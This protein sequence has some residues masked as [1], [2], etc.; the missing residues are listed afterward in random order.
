MTVQHYSRNP[1]TLFNFEVY[2]LA[3]RACVN[4]CAFFGNGGN[5]DNNME[6]LKG[7]VSHIEVL[8]S[9]M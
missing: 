9:T 1:K 8:N 4:D 7:Q 5:D 3:V 6:C 2:C